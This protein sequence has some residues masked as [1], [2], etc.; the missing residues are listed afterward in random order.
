LQ[1]LMA[2]LCL[3]LLTLALAASPLPLAEVEIGQ[4]GYGL[5]AGPG[6]AIER[7]SVEVL[8]VQDDLGPGFPLVLIRVG[9]DFIERSGGVAAGMSGSPVYIGERLLGALA[10]AF[11]N[12]DHRLALVTPIEAILRSDPRAQA[13]FEDLEDIVYDGK[14][15]GAAVPIRTPIVLSGLSQRA[16]EVLAPLFSGEI[17]PLQAGRMSA[18]EDERYALEPGGAISVQLV[19][20]DITVAAVGTV[21]MI[22]DGRLWAFG[23][24]LIE[25]GEVS[26]A[27]TPAYISHIVPNLAIPFKLANSGQRLLGSIVQD[28]PSGI[29][30]LLGREPDFIP[31]SLTFSGP[32][33]SVTK[34][35]EVTGDERFYSP[36][37]LAASLQAL[38]E[39][40]EQLD[41]G[42][43]ELAWEI[44]LASGETVRILEQTADRNDIAL[45][46]ASLAAAPLDTLATNVYSDPEV[47]RVSLSVTYDTDL[48]FAEIVR[49]VAENEEVA[50]GGT[51]IAHVR[52]QP[53]RGE[54]SVEV[55]RVPI[56][57]DAPAGLFDV[58]FRGGMEASPEEA[59]RGDNA[60]LTFSELITALEER[61]QAS[62]LVAEGFIDGEYRR[63]ARVPL[64]FLVE[65]FENVL[66]TVLGEE[67][68]E[69]E[70]S[71][72]L[73]PTEP[74]EEL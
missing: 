27:L 47:T 44:T 30:G 65:G 36:L 14:A 53:Y 7:F 70:P 74:E 9:G 24:S 25:R 52:L 55:V 8:S 1:K 19:R 6:N 10:Y 63:L 4:Q 28:R 12:S 16:G 13:P 56:P 71:E 15:L 67:E 66:I 35:F 2:L 49:V 72:P 73:P 32:L 54:P 38:D 22:E 48:R 46:A 21:T 62:E 59:Q 18:A 61:V 57:E 43:A 23:H 20:G 42:T 3:S 33:G 40:L 39:I 58:S 5:T 17:L 29:S 60:I 45:A 41:G 51:F 37:V 26:F 34:R 50:P 64:P 11:P 31:I 68:G 69:E